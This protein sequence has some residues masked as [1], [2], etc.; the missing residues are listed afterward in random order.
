MSHKP[1]TTVGC[2]EPIFSPQPAHTNPW[3]FAFI[4]CCTEHGLLLIPPALQPAQDIPTLILGLSTKHWGTLSGTDTQQWHLP[5]KVHLLH[6]GLLT[7]CL[8]LPY[9]AS[10]ATQRTKAKAPTSE[11]KPNPCSSP[12]TPQPLLALCQKRVRACFDN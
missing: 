1:P 11:A 7:V 2:R 10:N 3:M 6:L 8:L 12:H 5:A 9:R 4:S